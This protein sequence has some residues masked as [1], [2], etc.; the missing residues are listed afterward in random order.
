MDN[1]FGQLLEH[2]GYTVK[3]SAS[4]TFKSGIGVKA[5]FTGKASFGM[6]G[7]GGGEVEA[8]G[9]LA[10]A[11][12]AVA[13]EHREFVVAGPTDSK[14]LSVCEKNALWL[15]L[16]E[17]HQASPEFKDELAGFLKAYAN[18]SCE[19]FRIILLGTTSDTG[20]L[21]K[22]DPG[23]DRLLQDV[24]LGAMSEEE[25]Q[26]LVSTGFGDL[27]I[28]PEDGVIEQMVRTSVGSP[29]ILQF[30]A[31]EVGGHAFAREPRVATPADVEEAIHEYVAVRATRLNA[32]Y[33]AAC[34]TFGKKRYRMRIMSAVAHCPRE[35]V[36]LEDIRN[37]VSE[38]LGERV[39]STALSGPLR[40]LKSDGMG[41]ILKDVERPTAEG[42][43]YNMTTFND[44]AMKAFIRMREA[45]ERSG[46]D[47]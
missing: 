18:H 2:V 16:D 19:N 35:F 23:I 29:S 11:D 47:V 41:P 20:D 46:V 28:S 1:V 37:H 9:E 17:L 12:E 3:R 44:P 14:L 40:T 15:I 21:V 24:D 7:A 10:I 22:K 32:Q 5:T 8:G 34:E 6:P 43:V 33:T 25:G 4:E 31:L 45:A 39:P 30:L 36:T 27:R 38:A 26:Q 13:E 42:R